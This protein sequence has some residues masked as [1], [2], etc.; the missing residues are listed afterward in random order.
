MFAR[1][2][3]RDAA[4]LR[5]RDNKGFKMTFDRSKRERTTFMDGEFRIED[6]NEKGFK[7]LF[8]FFKK[9]LWIAK[10]AMNR[11]GSVISVE[12]WIVDRHV[13]GQ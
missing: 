7:V 6:E 9:S 11:R 5:L 3:T 8:T 10:E 1:V 2:T 13:Y 12:T 4:V